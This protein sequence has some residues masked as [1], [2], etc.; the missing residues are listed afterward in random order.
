MD[1][2]NELG[3]RG[4][5]PHSTPT[6]VQRLA[7]AGVASEFASLPDCPAD[8]TVEDA[9]THVLGHGYVDDTTTGKPALFKRGLVSLSRVQAGLVPLCSVVPPEERSLLEDDATS[10]LLQRDCA[11]RFEGRLAFDARLRC[12]PRLYGRFLGD[13]S[14]KRLIAMGTARARVCP[15]CGSKKRRSPALDFRHSGST[16]PFCATTIQPEFVV[17][18]DVTWYGTIQGAG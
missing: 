5:P 6:S 4:L 8:V 13:L 3:S 17:T 1:A 2:I 16:S 14:R 7:L 18:S 15:F 11:E 12:H 9:I 10:P